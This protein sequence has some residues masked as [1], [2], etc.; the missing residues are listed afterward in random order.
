MADCRRASLDKGALFAALAVL[1]VPTGCAPGLRKVSTP[2]GAFIYGFFAVPDKVGDA[3]CV[4]II[5]DEKVGIAGRAGCMSTSPEGLFFAED[6]P[7]MRYNV[8]GF[9][10]DNTFN[11]LGAMAKPFALKP[12]EFR[13]YGIYK[14][15]VVSKP[16]LVGQGK[17]SLTPGGPSHAEVLRKLLQQESISSKWKKRIQARLKELGG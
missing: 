9:Y 2:D 11:A 15:E 12:G 8:H 7:P 5:Q 10:V 1:A 14:Y 17:F 3:N 16:F 4:G 13:L 6:L